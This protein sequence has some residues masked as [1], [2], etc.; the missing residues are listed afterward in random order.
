MSPKMQPSKAI[1]FYIEKFLQEIINAPAHEIFK[2]IEEYNKLI[3]ENPNNAETIFLSSIKLKYPE[4]QAKYEKYN[5]ETSEKIDLMEFI[6][7]NSPFLNKDENKWM[8][9]I[10]NI[11]RNTSIY[12]GPQMRTKII[13]EGWASYWHDELFRTDKRIQGHEISYAKLNA[14]VTSLSR[15]GLNP[16]AIGLRLI[17]YVEELAEKGQIDYNFQKIEDIQVKAEYNKKTGKGK[18]SIFSLRKNFSDFMLINTFTDQDFVNKHDL[19]VVGERYNDEKGVIEYYVKSRQAKDYKK[20]LI[21]SLYHPPFITVDKE[22]TTENNLYLKHHF[23]GKQL[24]KPY[25]PDTLIGI[26]FLWGGQVQLE[27]TEIIPVKDDSQVQK[28]NYNK[29]LYTINNK[30][31]TKSTL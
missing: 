13:N 28:F 20:M 1:V 7:E 16:Y 19:F 24:Y 11:V 14:G 3:S 21:D 4:F 5:I 30:K 12:F 23:E 2:E 25:I 27:T 10:M 8:R 18:E 9:S 31:V 26:E 15:I 29:V 6:S 22:K 17:Q